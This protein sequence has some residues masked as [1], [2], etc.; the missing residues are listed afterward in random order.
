MPLEPFRFADARDLLSPY[1]AQAQRREAVRQAEVGREARR[2]GGVAWSGLGPGDAG[3]APAQAEL[4][5]EARAALARAQAFADS[6]RG[7]F[8]LGVRALDELGYVGPAERARAAFARGFADP[9][10]PACPAEIGAALSILA[11]LDR[12]EAR[13]ACLALAELLTGALK[14]AAE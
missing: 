10:R 3:P 9:E 4:R 2:C 14:V 7:R 11:R 1:L 12:P 5:E 13:A 6:P 8:L